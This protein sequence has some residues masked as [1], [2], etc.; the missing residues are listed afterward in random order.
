MFVFNPRMQNEYEF[1]KSRLEIFCKLVKKWMNENEEKKF[2]WILKIHT[3]NP[4]DNFE[5]TIVC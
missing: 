4:T 5:C 2:T 3:A 1:K